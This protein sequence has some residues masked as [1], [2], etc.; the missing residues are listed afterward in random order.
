[1]YINVIKYISYFIKDHLRVSIKSS[2]NTLGKRILS[3]SFCCWKL[4]KPTTVTSLSVAQTLAPSQPPTAYSQPA[5]P[6]Y[7]LNPVACHHK[8]PW[9]V[10]GRQTSICGWALGLQS[11][12]SIWEDGHRDQNARLPIAVLPLNKEAGKSLISMYFGS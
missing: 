11:N 8:S 1:M 12:P 5:C 3:R 2:Y 6:V 9:I 10:P 7:P 4:L